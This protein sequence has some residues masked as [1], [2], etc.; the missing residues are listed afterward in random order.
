M[1]IPLTWTYVEGPTETKNGIAI[2]G[3]FFGVL[4]L[5][6]G[7]FGFIPAL[8]MGFAGSKRAKKGA[9]HGGLATTAVVLGF[10][11]MAFFSLLLAQG[12]FTQ[13]IGAF[14]YSQSA[15]QESPAPASSGRNSDSDLTAGS[16]RLE[17]SADGPR[18]DADCTPGALIADAGDYPMCEAGFTPTGPSSDVAK[19]RRESVAAAYSSDSVTYKA[20][21]VG[22]LVPREL[23]GSWAATNLWPVRDYLNDAQTSRLLDRLCASPRTLTVEEL[24]EAARAGR[25]RE[26]AAAPGS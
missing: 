26:L 7:P 16:C 13:M 9:P 17:G 6:L 3:V 14:V 22:F 8:F 1:D 11:G 15:S 25:L 4:G 12:F 18:P 2:A 21:D 20:S 5:C 24:A 19:T 23:G 10:I